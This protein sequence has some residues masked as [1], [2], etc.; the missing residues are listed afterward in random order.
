MEF[1]KLAN[2]IRRHLDGI[3]KPIR[4]GI[5]SAVVEVLNNKFQKAFKRSY[6]FKA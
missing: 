3:M 6:K 5:N 2:T 1:I 4:T